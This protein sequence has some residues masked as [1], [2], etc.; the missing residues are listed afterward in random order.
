MLILQNVKH[1]LI[2]SEARESIME[3]F[4]FE[5]EI[6]LIMELLEERKLTF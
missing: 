5:V 2:K 4:A 1:Y 3:T 6:L